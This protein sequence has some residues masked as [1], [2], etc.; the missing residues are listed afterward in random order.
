MLSANADI[1]PH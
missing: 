1:T